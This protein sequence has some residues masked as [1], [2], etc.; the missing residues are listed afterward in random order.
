MRRF[1]VFA[2]LSILPLGLSAA[3]LTLRDGSV[4]Y[5]Q[6]LGGSSHDIV[7]QDDRG[8]R[9]NF[10]LNQVQNLDFSSVNT[11]SNVFQ[12]NRSR[13]RN[14]S[15]RYNNND[16]YNPYNS[17]DRIDNSRYGNMYAELPAGTEVAVRTNED[18]NAQ[19]AVEG[20]TYSATVD[21]DVNDS[22][23]NVVIPRGSD[24]EM[25][26]RQVNEGGTLTSGNLIL[27]LQ[28]VR[29]NGRRYLVSTTDVQQGGNQGIGKNRRT[30]E[31]VGGGALLGT[32]I[33]AI[34]GGG[35]GAA[36]GALGGAVA[37]GAAQVATK[38]KEIRVPAET[39]LTF[40]LDQPLQLREAR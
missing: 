31:F 1:A 27:D 5:G 9:R 19:T 3:R 39:Q 13:D 30:G 12:D 16:R 23:G 26:I 8:V 22:S 20:R 18:I 11:S 34:A 15:N 28:S 24:A 32:V 38:G 6:F 10:D 17:A 4:I 37:G 33:G 36:I 25:V 7:F 35:K 40:R 29:V 2:I 14:D 21:R